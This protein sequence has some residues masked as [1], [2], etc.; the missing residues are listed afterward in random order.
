MRIWTGYVELPGEGT[1]RG[2]VQSLQGCGDLSEIVKS[3]IAVVG[4]LPSANLEEFFEQLSPSRSRT[5]TLGLLRLNHSSM[6]ELTR[7]RCTEVRSSSLHR[8][9]SSWYHLIHDR[10][11][12]IFR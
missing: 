2:E 7:I 12:K 10:E 1:F 6:D 11:Y 5:V 4:K 8:K 9:V 3:T